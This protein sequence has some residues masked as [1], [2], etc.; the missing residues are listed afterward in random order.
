M[1][2]LTSVFNFIAAAMT[3]GLLA[4]IVVHTN[5]VTAT[6][7]TME[8]S[9]RYD[10]A[11]VGAAGRM[12]ILYLQKSLGNFING[13]DPQDA[14]QVRL[15][16]DIMTNRFKI[17]EAPGFQA[18]MDMKPKRRV[19]I[20][21]AAAEYT[22]IRPQLAAVETL[23]PQAIEKLRQS[24][25]KVYAAV[26]RVGAEAQAD[27]VNEAAQIRAEMQGKQKLQ[28]WLASGLFGSIA[29]LLAIST[30]QNR[31]LR[32]ATRTALRSAEDFSYIAHHDNL[33]GLPNRM[34]FTREFAL[35]AAACGDGD[36]KK[37]AV[38]AI[39]LDGFK[40]INDRLGHTTGDALLKHVAD[41]ISR[42]CAAFANGILSARLGGDE[43]VVVLEASG[44][45]DG[46]ASQ[47]EQLRQVLSQTYVIEGS[48]LA[49][50]VSVGIAI[51]VPG[52]DANSLLIDADIALSQAKAS[53]RGRI[54]QFDPAMRDIFLRRAL[55]QSEL[56][57]AITNDMIIPHYQIKMDVRTGRVC[58]VEA[59]ARWTHPTLGNVPPGEFTKIAEESGLIVDL[60]RK[61]LERACL[62]GLHFPAEICVAV[63]LSASQF[64][65]EDIVQTVREVLE[66]TGFPASRLTLEVTETLM[67]S[68]A[69]RA[70]EILSRF[71]E[72]GISIALDDFG[73]GFSALSYLRQF[74][75]DEL[76]IDRA[77]VMEMET[78]E[79]ARAIV[80][81]IAEMA[82]RLGISVT[83]EGAETCGQIEALRDAGC[84]TIQ[85]YHFGRP[86]SFA[87][88]PLAI[89]HG[90]A[91]AARLNMGGSSR[92][93]GRKTT[94]A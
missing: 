36:T 56:T 88:L 15:F 79:R 11:W 41:R 59:L 68:E 43:F 58:G 64:I 19:L 83:A 39:D 46:I 82:R 60:G 2:R 51:S 40:N 6:Q 57:V 77:F 44:D 69:D 89:L 34:A 74:P 16:A 21:A 53:G 55:I 80:C 42:T 20:E 76:K 71:R 25:E 45:S 67:I 85:G 17:Y 63:N 66:V 30:L 62:D 50:G 91:T 49:V 38:L 22:E 18:F 29:L 87:E 10:S 47:A 33:T 61:I 73:T 72:M 35:A 92:P 84:E 86:V 90:V 4:I 52:S 32:A 48:S 23:D 27:S 70:V 26:D 81:S 24:L 65:R 31:F 14:A 37:I 7:Q 28:T 93:P 12:E 94:A 3:I 13:R 54:M 78:D 1:R 5:L 9:S 75:W 8:R